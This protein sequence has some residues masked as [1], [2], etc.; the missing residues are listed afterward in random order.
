MLKRSH[1]QAMVRVFRII[2]KIIRPFH[3]QTDFY[4]IVRVFGT[5][6]KAFLHTDIN[7]TSLRL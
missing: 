2:I 6:I 5:I 1:R 4:R 7:S 3:K